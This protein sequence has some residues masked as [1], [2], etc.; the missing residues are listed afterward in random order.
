M[1]IPDQSDNVGQLSHDL[2]PAMGTPGE[3]F[4]AKLGN[5]IISCIAAETLQ[6]GRFVELDSSDDDTGDPIVRLPQGTTTSLT[7]VIGV[8]V[9]D[10]QREQ[11]S[12]PDNSAQGYAAGSRVAVMRR[13]RIFVE[14]DTADT[15]SVARLSSFNIMHSSTNS[16]KRGMVTKASTSTSS[17]AEVDSYSSMKVFED[18]ETS[19]LA[20]IDLYAV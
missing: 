19:G 2:I 12:W 17:G 16:A 3:L 15:A 14:R 5:D 1:S 10:Q 11:N 6:P 8:V 9:R 18:T 13:G 7:N 4:D 20:L